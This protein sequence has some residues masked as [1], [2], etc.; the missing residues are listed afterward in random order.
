MREDVPDVKDLFEPRAV[1]I[2]GA[3]H[4]NSKLG[5]HVTENIVSGGY[6]GKV[7]PINPRGGEICGQQVYKSIEDVDDDIDLVSIVVPAKFVYEA[8]KSCARKTVKFASIITSGFAEVGN[9]EEEQ[10]IVACA[11]E[12]GMRIQG[13]NIFGIY[14]CVSS[15]NATFSASCPEPGSV[16]IIT[17]SGA[18]GLGMIGKTAIEHLGLSAIVSVG[19]KSDLDEADLLEYLVPQEQT[20]VIFMYIEGVQDGE[21]LIKALSAATRVKPVIVLKSGRSARGAI[22]A[23]SHT[24]SLA[25]SDEVFNEIMRQ[26]GVLRAESVNEGFDWCKFIATSPPPLGDNTVIITNGG[27]IGVIATDA[28]EKYGVTLYDDSA[29]LKE[30]FT[31]VTPDF[32]STKNPVDITGQAGRAEYTL[33]LD[34]ALKHQDMH[35][36]MALY[37]ETA[38]FDSENLFQMIIENSQKYRLGGKPLV[39]SVFGGRKSRDCITQCRD[40]N[41]P[42]FGDVY[43]AVSC[44]GALYRYY[45][46]KESSPDSAAVADVD[47]EAI[48]HIAAHAI[49]QNRFFLLA[50]EAQAIMKRSG[51]EIPKSSIARNLDEAV[52]CTEDI[53]YPVVMKVVSKDII[54]KSDA[55]G[56]ALDLDNRN[57]VIDAYQA[58]MQS[59]RAYN[60]GAMIEGVEIAEMVKPGTELIIGA[61]RDATFGPI[62]MVGLGGIYVEV[63][64]DV[65]F[66]SYP[67]GRTEIMNMIKDIRSYP[68]LLGVR[69]EE[70]K[71][72]DG[73][74]DMIIKLGSIIQ[75]CKSISDIE[76]NPLRVYEGRGVKAVDV[77]ILLSK[78]ERSNKYE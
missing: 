48:E 67:L 23:A 11:R 15:L 70:K 78:V 19:N 35:T 28:S 21:K 8:V 31:A 52:R 73:V 29:T 38:V 49:Q 25:G 39:F 54:H 2:I 63:M 33:A 40:Q 58:I 34:A 53:G 43:E 37:C 59:C 65:T 26:C 1:A 24:G 22:A 6:R 66:R 76:I 62:V 69:G 61:R 75:Q 77:R 9:V 74:A 10:K 12:H 51:V 64:K 55:G 17:Q 27:G 7:Y 68:L 36:V 5:Y 16:A 30:A 44:M 32:G 71:D 47:V 42:V 72:I 50:H 18:L 46:Y 14:S 41:I 3:S 20:K 60:P 13:P 57:E 45:N 4:D 56:V